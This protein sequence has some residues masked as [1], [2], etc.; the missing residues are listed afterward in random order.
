MLENLDISGLNVLPSRVAASADREFA[1]LTHVQIQAVQVELKNLS[2]WYKDKRAT[3]AV[4]EMK[5]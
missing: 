1:T 5:V 3:V 4:A 2:F